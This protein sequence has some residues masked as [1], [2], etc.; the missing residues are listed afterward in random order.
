MICAMPGI[1]FKRAS[2]RGR[3][4]AS[5]RVG[6]I[7]EIVM[8]C[9]HGKVLSQVFGGGELAL[10]PE[11]QGRLFSLGNPWRGEKQLKFILA[12]PIKFL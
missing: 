5:L 9:A 10:W 4:A 11:T 1:A 7:T 8:I 2:K 6:M 12:L 3:C